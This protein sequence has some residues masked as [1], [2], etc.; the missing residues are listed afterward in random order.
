MTRVWIQK[1]N[2][3]QILVTI[4]STCRSLSILRSLVLNLDFF[5]L[6][7]AFLCY[8]IAAAMVQNTLITQVRN[9]SCATLS[10]IHTNGSQSFVGPLCSLLSVKRTSALDVLILCVIP[11]SNLFQHQLNSHMHCCPQL[12]IAVNLPGTHRNRVAFMRPAIC[13]H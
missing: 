4:Q 7:N 11:L 10:L 6:I 5:L 3:I 9:K 12:N 1:D 8:A 2:I 13:M